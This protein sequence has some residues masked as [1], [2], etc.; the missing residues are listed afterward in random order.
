MRFRKI[1]SSVV[2]SRNRQELLSKKETRS[3]AWL[4]F[5]FLFVLFFKSE[6]IMCVYSAGLG[7]GKEKESMEYKNR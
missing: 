1:W 3:K 7:K 6:I 5:L 2:G 4:I